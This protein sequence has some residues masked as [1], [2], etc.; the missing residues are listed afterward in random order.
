MVKDD[1]LREVEAL[2][3]AKAQ[4]EQQETQ[5]ISQRYKVL[6]K[7]KMEGANPFPI[8]A[9][10]KRLGDIA[11]VFNT[12]Y[13]LPI[14]YYGLGMLTAASIAIGN[15]YVVKYKFNQCYPPMLYS[16]IV[17]NSSIGKTP[18]I[19]HCLA[20]IFEL[21]DQYRHQYDGQLQAWK[22]ECFELQVSG[23][24]REDPPK[25]VQRELII[26][27]ATSEAI[28]IAL[29][30]NPRG[31]LLFQDELNAWISSQNQYRKGSDGEFWLSV[32]S[33]QSRKV[34]RVGK[35][36]LYAKNPFVSVIGGVQPAILN[37]FAGEGRSENG[38]LARILFAWPDEMKK[39]HDSENSPDPEVFRAYKEII[40]RLHNL[41]H[42][43]T[44]EG[45]GQAI[46]IGLT[47]RALK[48]YKNW[49]HDNTNQINAEDSD[50]IK[51]IL[52]KMEQYLLRI[53]LIISLLDLAIEKEEWTEE[54][55]QAHQ[56]GQ[57]DVLRAIFLISY[58]KKTAMRVIGSVE[59]PT[60]K[61][62]PEK[63]AFYEAL[64]EE[65]STK[66][67]IEAGDKASLGERTVKR[68][69]N[70]FTLFRQL[71]RGKYRKVYI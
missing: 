6:L 32:W 23:M 9:L 60:K 37:N 49:H 5:E 14:D 15:T 36:P 61:L 59:N 30:H 11:Q 67:A 20:P 47:D 26:N 48:A 43:F 40:R 31:L 54:E 69:L 28:T 3:I 17:G 19:M 53:A 35:D 4:Q 51:S 64:P 38:Y 55:L 7:E 45:F 25:P 13:G 2:A 24:K 65:F 18:A 46:E 50:V 12:C 8:N 29:S 58:F 71:G 68:M 10:P 1:L 39:P 21:E 34:S 22:Q 66:S 16:A 62:S 27:D 70:D 33:G 63:E 57:D 56:I 52:G 42:N 41:P 44:E